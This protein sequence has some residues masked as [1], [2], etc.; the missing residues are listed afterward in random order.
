M[1]K[2]ADNTKHS[3]NVCI[4]TWLCPI[5]SQK[6]PN[7]TFWDPKDFKVL[8]LQYKIPFKYML[9]QQIVVDLQKIYN[10]IEINPISYSTHPP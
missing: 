8:I 6:L 7:M 4:F 1:G 5:P 3:P 9:D 10:R 2:K